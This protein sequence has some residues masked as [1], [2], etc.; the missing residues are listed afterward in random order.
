MKSE[1]EKKQ[2][3]IRIFRTGKDGRP[4]K[5]DGHIVG[6]ALGRKPCH[7]ICDQ[8]DGIMWYRTFKNGK[9]LRNITDSMRKGDFFITGIENG[10]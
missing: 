9:V 4:Y 1:R 2:R 3:N 10:Y 8:D 5:R 7:G 6:K